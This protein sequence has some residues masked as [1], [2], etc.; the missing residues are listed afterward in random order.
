MTAIAAF[1][2][3]IARQ[4]CGLTAAKISKNS[5]FWYKFF[6][7]K[8]SRWSIEKFEYRCTTRNFPLCNGTIIVLKIT[9][10]HGVSVITNFVIPKPDRQ[11]DKKHHTFSSTAGAR[12]TIPTIFGMM[13]E[14]IRAIFAPLTFLIWSVVS[15]LGAIKNLWE[16][17]P[18]A[19]KCL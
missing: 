8:K 18:T 4:K 12:P 11:T 6:P 16:N 7:K 5:N 15:P 19:E 14:E 10:L 3:S 1:M 17:A 13:I 9:L 2:H